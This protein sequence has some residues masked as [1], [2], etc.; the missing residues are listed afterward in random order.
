MGV[1]EDERDEVESPF[2]TGLD[3]L[4]GKLEIA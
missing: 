1:L 2:S 3:R 4:I